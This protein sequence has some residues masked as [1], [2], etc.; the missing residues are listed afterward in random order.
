MYDPDETPLSVD[1]WNYLAI[2]AQA[3]TE[4]LAGNGLPLTPMGE[5]DVRPPLHED[6][7]VAMVT[8][9][10]HSAGGTLVLASSPGILRRSMPYDAD[11]TVPMDVLRDWCGELANQVLGRVKDRL[12]RHGATIYV[13]TPRTFIC[14]DA[15]FG[16]LDPVRTVGQVLVGVN[17]HV[18]AWFEVHGD[19]YF[20]L[21]G[22]PQ[23][24]VPSPKHHQI[25]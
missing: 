6:D 4:V 8:F 21:E 13:G 16:L 22:D 18:F 10:G 20:R 3:T 9:S 19:A 24:D 17:A 2:L 7:L 1:A 14:A 5:D 15:P 25:F 23:I 12:V 11:D